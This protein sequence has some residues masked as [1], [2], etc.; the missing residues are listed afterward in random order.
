MPKQSSLVGKIGLSLRECEFKSVPK[1]K[2]EM[3]L[4]KTSSF[5]TPPMEKIKPQRGRNR[6]LTQGQL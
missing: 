6:N 4:K 5:M 2:V 1:V 3:K